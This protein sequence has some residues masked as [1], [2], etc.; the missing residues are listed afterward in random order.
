MVIKT[1]YINK[2]I[3]AAELFIGKNTFAIS[4]LLL[5]IRYYTHLNTVSNP[6]DFYSD[7][8]KSV[9]EREK[10]LLLDIND[11]TELYF[12]IEQIIIDYRKLY[13]SMHQQS[14]EVFNLF[15]KFNSDNLTDEMKSKLTET[16]FDNLEKTVKTKLSDIIQLLDKMLSERRKISKYMRSELS[17]YD[18]TK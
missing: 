17:E 13:D 11:C 4:S 8:M 16:D 1:T 7:M 14:D 3:Q 10:E 15:A 2:K 12:G 18:L 5:M 6:Q 9:A